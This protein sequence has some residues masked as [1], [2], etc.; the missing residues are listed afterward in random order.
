MLFILIEGWAIKF[1]HRY[2]DGKKEK[3]RQNTST[4]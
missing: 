2:N 4:V 1:G 3:N